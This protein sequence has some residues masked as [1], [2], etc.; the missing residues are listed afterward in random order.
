MQA[1][2]GS[3]PCSQQPGCQSVP[4]ASWIYPALFKALSLKLFLISYPMYVSPLNAGISLSAH[5]G[6]TWCLSSQ[7]QSPTPTSTNRYF[8]LLL[9]KFSSSLYP[10]CYFLLTPFL[11]CK[12]SSPL[13]GPSSILSSSDSLIPSRAGWRSKL[14]RG[15]NTAHAAPNVFCAF[16]KHYLATRWTLQLLWN[17]SIC[18]KRKL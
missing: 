16:Q 7:S 18:N 10:S 17:N 3:L 11:F 9:N 12:T 8:R 14:L 15:T 6:V 2:D 4:W 1:A 13:W 5:Y